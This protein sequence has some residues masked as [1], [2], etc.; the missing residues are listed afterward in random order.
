MF[1]KPNECIGCPMYD[2]G[3]GF[4]PDELT[5]GATTFIL[6]QNPG[7]Q[8]EDEGK[9]FCGKPG[10]V[11]ENV[12]MPLAGLRR[13]EN[14]SIGN[15]LKCRWR[16]PSKRDVLNPNGKKTNDMPPA[17]ILNKAI[18]H[19]MEA[20]LRI[21]A[22]VDLIIATGSIAWKAMGNKTSISDWRGYLVDGP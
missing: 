14:V 16:N 21:P 15:V 5:P 1:H 4:V 6:G 22:E 10:W 3:Q 19:C 8:E 17:M 9:P 13:G 7:E 2:D 12:Y 20:H 18:K 11:M